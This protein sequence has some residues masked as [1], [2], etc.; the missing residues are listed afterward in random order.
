M[1]ENAHLIPKNEETKSGW[2]RNERRN[3]ADAMAAN[4][5]LLLFI[6]D[7]FFLSFLT[8]LKQKGKLLVSA[9]KEV[10]L[11]SLPPFSPLEKKKRIQQF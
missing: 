4:E 9:Q 6:P 10:Q 2:Q 1:P 5:N 11:F 3:G 8:L 7:L